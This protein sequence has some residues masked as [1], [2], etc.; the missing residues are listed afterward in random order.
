MKSNSEF[1]WIF[2]L[3]VWYLTFTLEIYMYILPET[4]GCRAV[5]QL[6]Y[7]WLCVSGIYGSA[8]CSCKLKLIPNGNLSFGLIWTN[9]PESSSHVKMTYNFVV[10][11]FCY[12]KSWDLCFVYSIHCT[13]SLYFFYKIN[14]FS[15]S[16]WGT[17]A[18][19]L[20]VKP[21]PNCVQLLITLKLTS[22]NSNGLGMPSTNT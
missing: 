16:I 21:L 19:Y 5:K 8:D 3:K 9:C 10:F 14:P 15:S 1:W 11:S 7:K 20:N 17:L 22:L 6:N 12:G 13:K 4:F 2:F 18:N